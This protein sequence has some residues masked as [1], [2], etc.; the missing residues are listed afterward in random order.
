MFHYDRGLKLTAIDLALDYRRRQPRGFISHAHADHMARHEFAYCTPATAALYHRKFGV[1]P[2]KE[3]PYR[4]PML[5]GDTQ[6]TTFP[7]GH[8][9]GSA[10][11]FADNGK[12]TFL[13]T[14]DFKLG[15]SAT[16]ETAELPHADILVIESTF[17]YPE[18]RLPPRDEVIG[19]FLD[20]VRA[21]FEREAT[22]VIEAYALGKSQEVTRILTLTGI[23]VLQHPL[24]YE[25]SQVYRACGVDLG[26]VYPYVDRAPI[27][28][29]VVTPPKMQRV[30]RLR[31]LKNTVSF[32]LSGWAQGPS[33]YRLGVDHAIP[34]SDHAD[35]D[36]LFEAIEKV[37]PK[38]IHCTHGP[39]S[40]VDHLRAAGLNAFP[41]DRSKQTMQQKALNLTY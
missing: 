20:L 1:R 19:Q 8:C 18:Y 30:N 26:E 12:S 9:L 29:A 21:A 15:E 38:E 2:V 3:M 37:N 11:L 10:M 28:H 6:L 31:G 27:G 36:D 14:G 22:P 39:T 5:M 25:I 35:F 17:G 4:T 33:K 23:P 7:A 41:L 13:Y 40:F 16:S 24:I 32:A 34:L